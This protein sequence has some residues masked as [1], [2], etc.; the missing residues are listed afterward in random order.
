MEAAY[1]AGPATFVSKDDNGA[2]SREIHAG[3]LLIRSHDAA[4][5]VIL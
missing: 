1:A 5:A 4:N 3:M 2:K